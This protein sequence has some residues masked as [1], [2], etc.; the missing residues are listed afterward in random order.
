MFIEI[1][2][3]GNVDT[4]FSM[5]YREMGEPREVFA[6]KYNRW[7]RDEPVQVTGW[8]AETNLP[9]PAYACR[10]EESGDGVALL[11]YGGS[12]GLRLKDLEDDSPWDLHSPGQWGE[13]HLVYPKN[14][15]V[16]YMDE[17]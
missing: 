6:I 11:I 1:E 3:C 17:L 14:A 2:P 15:F 7:G 4:A 10:I 9:C 16:V 12:G 8:D 13:T 5:M